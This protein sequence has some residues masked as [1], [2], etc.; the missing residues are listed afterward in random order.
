MSSPNEPATL[1]LLANVQLAIV[2]L[3]TGGA[4]AVALRA[5]G[6][7]SCVTGATAFA[8][9]P[10]FA[11]AL[12][13]SEAK[14]AAFGTVSA[15]VAAE[16]AAALIDTYEGGWGLAVLCGGNQM[17]PSGVTSLAGNDAVCFIALGTPSTT[18]VISCEPE[19]TVP[20]ALALLQA[21]AA[22]RLATK[23]PY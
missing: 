10:A 22:T 2:E 14:M 6:A 21:A 9:A 5:G 20:S 16:A 8:G 13:V 7:A 12:R 11:T 4:V 18:E 17:T 15:M 1:L 23:R 3:G 19:R